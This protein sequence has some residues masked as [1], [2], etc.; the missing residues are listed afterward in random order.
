MDKIEFHVTAEHA[1]RRIDLQASE[2]SGITR[3]QIQ[4][5]IEKGLVVVNY[6]SVKQNY[7]TKPGDVISITMPEKSEKLTPENIPI[8]I[9]YLDDFVIVVNKPS[10]MVVYPSAGHIGGTLMNAIAYHS[11]KLASIGAPLR[12]GVVHRLDKDTSG[13]M[14][15]AL[16]DSAYYSL[17]EQFRERTINRK[18][19]AV[20]FGD[21]KNDSGEISFRIGRSG[22]DRKKMSTRAKRAKEA[23]TRWDVIERFHAATLIEARLGTGRTHQIRVHFASI[24]H[25]VLGDNTYGRKTSIEIRK[26]KIIFLRQ[27]LHASLLGFIHPATGKYMEFSGDLPDDMEKTIRVL[28]EAVSQ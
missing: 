11:G 19:L 10:G 3:S 6:S 2:M 15:I 14:I 24:G 23:I 27:M 18:Y 16:D 5:F 7:R 25:P 1:G 21:L 12:P 9:M 28:R 22:S 20:V 26:R 4:H 13:V 8:E 17:V